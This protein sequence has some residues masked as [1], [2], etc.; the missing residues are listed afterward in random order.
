MQPR[1]VTQNGGA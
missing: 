1:K